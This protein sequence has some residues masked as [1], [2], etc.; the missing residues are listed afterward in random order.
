[1]KSDCGCNLLNRRVINMITDFNYVLRVA[2]RLKGYADI[3]VHVL[4]T[5]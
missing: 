4:S 2:V 3:S 1:M 5:E